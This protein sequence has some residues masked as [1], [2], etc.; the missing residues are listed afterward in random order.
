MMPIPSPNSSP[1]VP[2]TATPKK[3]ERKSSFGNRKSSLNIL[4]QNPGAKL[5]F[6]D[7]FSNFEASMTVLDI[8][9]EFIAT[10]KDQLKA[11]STSST[12][13]LMDKTFF[14]FLILLRTVQPIRLLNH[15]FASLRSF[16]IKFHELLFVKK[17]HYVGDLCIELLRF[18]N[19][20]HYV[21]RTE[22]SSLLYLLVKVICLLFF[23]F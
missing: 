23:S 16:I 22:A 1:Q 9:E 20:A 15:L 14:I 12:S 18:C 3:I 5:K 6:K 10:C 13:L 4:A 11:T 2:T 21:L 7:N 17:N 8:T 19:S